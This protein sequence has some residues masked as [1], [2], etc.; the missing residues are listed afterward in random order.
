MPHT[1]P[2]PA[3]VKEAHDLVSAAERAAD[4]MLEAGKH[5]EWPDHAD[6]LAAWLS[7]GTPPGGALAA[8]IDGDMWRFANAADSFTWKAARGIMRALYSNAPRQAIGKPGTHTIA[9]AC[10][11]WRDA[12]E[13]AR[14]TLRAA[15][16]AQPA[17]DVPAGHCRLCGRPCDDEGDTYGE[18]FTAPGRGL[19]HEGCASYCDDPSSPWFRSGLD[20]TPEQRRLIA[21]AMAIYEERA[22]EIRA[23]IRNGGAGW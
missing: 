2:T 20:P 23:D 15:A 6:A 16:E 8:L 14:A 3:D 10:E 7:R 5:M 17:A 11:D 4:R 12:I 9:G 13:Q 18:S 22:R 1:P 21:E 19:E